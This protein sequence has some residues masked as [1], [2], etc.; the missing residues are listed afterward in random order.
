MLRK[1]ILTPLVDFKAPLIEA[2]ER[3]YTHPLSLF[4]LSRWL[5]PTLLQRW[6]QQYDHQGPGGPAV[7]S[8]TAGSGDVQ[9]HHEGV[10]GVPHSKKVGQYTTVHW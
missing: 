7:A 3:K 5:I 10:L 2:M 4:P 8:Y 1:D 9:D 6:P